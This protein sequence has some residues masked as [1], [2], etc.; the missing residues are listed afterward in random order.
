MEFDELLAQVIAL[1]QRQGRVS[2]GALKRRFKLDDD[3]LE[4]LKV[5]LIEAQGL[6]ADEQS[7]I[8]VWLGSPAAAP[9]PTAP[10]VRDAPQIPLAYTPPY[11]TEKILASRLSLEG[12]RK[13]VTVL[14]A[15]LKGSLELLADRDPEEARQLLD[16][17][18][19]R[20][21]E[22]VHR[23]E[24]TVNQVMGDG[25]MALFGAPIAHEDHVVRA[26][27]AALRMQESVK[28]YAADLQR[29]QGVPLHIRVGLNAGEVVVRSVASDLHMDYTAV[30]RTTHLAARM[31]QMAMPG[32]ILITPEVLGLAEGYVQVKPLGPVTIK[33]LNKPVEVYELT[34]A[35]PVQTRLQAAAARGLTRFVGRDSE[36][37]Q[38]RQALEL[39]GASHGQVVAVVGEPGVGKSRLVY[40]FARSHRTHGWLLLE[41]RAVSYS[42]ATPYLPVHDLLKG[43]F[44]IEAR[45]D[46]RK[47]REKVTGKLLTL[48]RALEP[49][50]PACLALLDVA[51]EDPQWQDLEPPRRRQRTLE[52]VK[53]LMLRESQAQPLLL[54]FEDLH[55]I[56]S[57]TQA[58]L[59]TLIES[60][61]TARLLLLVNYRPEY[62][63]TWGSKTFYTQLRLDPLSPASAHELLQSLL[64]DD[65]SLAPLKQLLIDRTEG[66]PFFLEESVRALFDQGIL[67]QPSIGTTAG[68]PLLTKPLTEFKLSATV[69]AVLAAR[70]DRLPAE[71]KRLLQTAAVIGTEVPLPLLQAIAEVSEE[72]LHNS[73][74]RLQAAEF[75]YESSLFPELEYTFKHA[76]THEVAYGGLLQ[77]RRRVLHRRIT[78]AVEE[79]Y[80]DHLAEHVERLAHHAFQG[81][82][83]DKAV[84]YLR[85]AGAKALARSAHRE[86]SIYSM[87]A[88]VALQHLPKRRDTQELGIDLRCDLRTSLFHLGEFEQIFEHLREAE[89]LAEGLED[90]E[91]LARVFDLRSANFNMMG[92]HGRAVDSS[93]RAFDLASGLGIPRLQAAA[94]FHLGAA[95][96]SLGDYRRAIEVLRQ[97]VDSLEN[98][99]LRDRPDRPSLGAVV[100]R[101][102]LVWSLAELGAFP[103]G[104]AHA[105]AGIRIAEEVN[106]PDSLINA[107]SA[108]GVLHLRQGHLRKAIPPL[109]RGF[110][111]YQDWSIPLLF[112]LVASALGAAYALAGRVA[113]ALPLLEQ[114]VEH[115]ASRRELDFLSHRLACLGEAYLFAGHAEDARALA[116]RALDLSREHKERGWEAYALR[117]LGEIAAQREPLEVGQTED[118]YRQATI[119]AEELGMRPLVAHCHLD[120]GTLH[121]KLGQLQQAH[122][123]LAAAV[124]L[125]R[126]MDMVF[127]L[128]QAE[129]ALAMTK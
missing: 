33:G 83:W 78:E 79:R 20:M 5:E 6:A 104:L 101:T 80:P 94:N 107:Y 36:L 23:Y 122:L 124:Q 121:A 4:D 31:E 40:E 96:Y 114:A 92:D 98:E 12:E 106:R 9:Q 112:P 16:A 76:L 70:I 54:V 3:Y 82:Q 75:L 53:R 118:Y 99:R 25:I 87:L 1:L 74:A 35:G 8:L 89:T 17:V 45:D 93:R 50:L 111:V 62:R 65:A 43:Y 10:S 38:L 61:P 24:G 39:A 67:A 91:R 37:D 73:L 15:D 113:E 46:G 55:W 128:P 60:L 102:W 68:S 57:E 90:R 115:A 21:M 116:G 88:L 77:Q 71:E 123:E 95:Y 58:L 51:V 117:L 59:D 97:N 81:E 30:G 127:W 63:H 13:Q 66:N 109:E 126:G 84:I 72:A 44:Q 85:Q 18:I 29:T 120:L 108:L 47:I 86:A 110:G 14:F 26:C 27:Y 41:T 52:A 2:Y 119:L 34:G 19:E 11:L 105:T 100:S 32:S 7:R 69:Q 64:G 56:D 49:T 103:E 28:A 129:A 48:D 125:Y 22:A 42:Q